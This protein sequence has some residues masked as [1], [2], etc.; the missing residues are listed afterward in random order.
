LARALPNSSV[1]LNTDGKAHITWTTPTVSAI[2]QESSSLSSTAAWQTTTLNIITN[3]CTR[4]VLA[5]A[6]NAAWFYRLA[7]TNPPA[8]FYL[9]TPTPLLEP[10]EWGM[11][12]VPDMHTAILQQSNT[13]HSIPG[14]QHP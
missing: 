2:L 6:T 7:S 1:N 9:G 13:Y 3:G 10:N 8:G 4:Q 5:P 11:T 12:D 14:D